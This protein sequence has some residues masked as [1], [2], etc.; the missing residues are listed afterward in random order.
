MRSVVVCVV[1]GCEDPDVGMGKISGRSK[2]TN[3]HDHPAK[4]AMPATITQKHDART[5]G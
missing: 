2:G 3:R 4:Q 5:V 1:V